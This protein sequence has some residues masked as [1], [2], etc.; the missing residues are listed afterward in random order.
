MLGPFLCHSCSPE[1]FKVPSMCQCARNGQSGPERPGRPNALD[2]PRASSNA[3]HVQ[4]RPEV[5]ARAG[6]FQVSFTSRAKAD[7][8]AC[9]CR[10]TSRRS[11]N[12]VYPSPHFM[13][14][15]CIKAAYLR[16]SKNFVI[17]HKFSAHILCYFESSIRKRKLLRS[18]AKFS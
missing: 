12:S 8:L 13:Q 15:S 2:Q 7:R 14:K 1:R 17:I 10:N 4:K 3:Q 16:P 5:N 11:K 18:D 6:C 9:A